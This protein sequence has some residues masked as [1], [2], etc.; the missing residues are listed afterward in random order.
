MY[1]GNRGVLRLNLIGNLKDGVVLETLRRIFG[2]V[3]IFRPPAFDNSRAPTGGALSGERRQNQVFSRFREREHS[4]GNG[5]NEERLGLLRRSNR[6]GEKLDTLNIYL[7][8][9]FSL[10]TPSCL[11]F[12]PFLLFMNNGWG[13]TLDSSSFSNL[14]PDKTSSST[15]QQQ[16]QQLDMFQFPVCSSTGE[17][18]RGINSS[19]DDNRRFAVDEVDFFSDVRED[20]KKT[21]ALTVVNIKKDIF[22]GESGTGSELDVNVG[23]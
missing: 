19:S 11:H 13:L 2:E 15:K 17:N 6:T 8:P 4:E 5:E 1:P 21:T 16:Q 20:K 14:F 12:L 23:V 22:H 7:H 18:C 10:S 3:S 9:M